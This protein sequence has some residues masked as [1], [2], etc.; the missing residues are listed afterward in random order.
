MLITNLYIL[1]R[2]SL[3]P[4]VAGGMMHFD[5][6]LHSSSSSS[7]SSSQQRGGHAQRGMRANQSQVCSYTVSCMQL[8]W[9]LCELLCIAVAQSDRVSKVYFKAMKSEG[10]LYSYCKHA[11]C[12]Y[13]TALN[14]YITS[15]QPVVVP[16]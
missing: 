16:L 2:H 9:A 1:L 15:S 13:C 10:S 12:L 8:H 14:N 5:P 7:T 6:V 4:L 11:A 3:Q